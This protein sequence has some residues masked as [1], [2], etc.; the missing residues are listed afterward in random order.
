R[1]VRM[2]LM[3]QII[4]ANPF[5]APQTMVQSYL[6]RAMPA[7]EGADAERVQEMRM[8]MWPAAEQALKRSLIVDRIAE[9]EALRATSAELESRIDQMAERMNLPR[10]EV[11]AQL[12]KAGRID[13]LEQEITEEKVFDYLKALSDIQ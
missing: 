11:V 5:E 8:Q 2:Q 13:E 10:G 6:E 9:M 1:G 12:R 7:R 4:E 3:Q